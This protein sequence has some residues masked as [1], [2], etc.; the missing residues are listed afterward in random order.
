MNIEKLKEVIARCASLDP[1]DAFGFEECWNEMTDIL[2]EDMSA[3][4]DFFK[5]QCTDEELF[6]LGAS[7]EDVAEITQS[8]EFIQ[9]LRDRLAK[10]DPKTYC[11]QNFKTEL[12]R[13]WIDY[14]EFVRCVTVDIDYAEDRIL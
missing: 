7:F 12:I 14:P 10:V 2:C 4:I 9:T 13:K 1:E 11:Q 6:W 8:R 3:T 5:N